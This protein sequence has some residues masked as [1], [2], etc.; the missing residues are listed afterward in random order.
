MSRLAEKQFQFLARHANPEISQPL[1]LHVVSYMFAG[2]DGP[3][4]PIYMS[5]A[6]IICS[7][8][9]Q[10]RA[11]TIATMNSF[12]AALTTVIQQFLYP[13]TDAPKYGKGFR[14]SLG[15][16]CGMVIWV[17]V[18]RWFEIW[19]TRKGEEEVVGIEPSLERVGDGIGDKDYYV[20]SNSVVTLTS[21]V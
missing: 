18:V 21:K 16:T 20:K 8:D 12:G 5:W 19:H 17:I 3:L 1:G 13:M 9:S 6:N 11:L 15:F 10:V 4:S 2:M 14:A 7:N